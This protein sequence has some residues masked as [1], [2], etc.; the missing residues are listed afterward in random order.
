MKNHYFNIIERKSVKEHRC[1]LCKGIIAK[2]EIYTYINSY[3]LIRKNL[4]VCLFH[5]LNE[6]QFTN[7]GKIRYRK[8]IL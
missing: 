3:S 8:K 1:S 5:D 4:K 7:F 6:I 2:D